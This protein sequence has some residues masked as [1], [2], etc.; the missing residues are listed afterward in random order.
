MSVFLIADGEFVAQGFVVRKFLRRFLLLILS[1]ALLIGAGWIF[2]NFRGAHEWTKAKE[3]AAKMG[4]N[5]N[6]ADYPAPEIAEKDRLMNNPIFAAEWN[7][8]VDPPLRRI[9]YMELPGV[10]SRGIRGTSYSKGKAFS[11]RQYFEEELTEEQAVEKLAELLTPVSARLDQLS[12]IILSYPVQEILPRTYLDSDTDVS[13]SA[14][15]SLKLMADCLRGEAQLAIRRGDTATALRNVRVL[16]RLR[17]NSRGPLVINLLVGDAILLSGSLV[18]WEGVRQHAWTENDLTELARLFPTELNTASGIEFLSYEAT[19]VETLVDGTLKD[20]VGYFGLFEDTENERTM[21]EEI[22]FW[23]NFKG[24]TGWQS[25]RK[26][27]VLHQYLD[28]L[29]AKDVWDEP[30]RNEFRNVFVVD[31]DEGPSFHPLAYFR[32]QGLGGMV[33]VIAKNT[34]KLRLIRIVISLEQYHLKHGS[35]P[36]TLSELELNFPIIDSTDPM[37]RPME[38]ER[39]P[40]GYFILNSREDDGSSRNRSEHWQFTENP[41]SEF[42]DAKKKKKN[43]SGSSDRS[44]G[45]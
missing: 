17:E 11:Y 35:Y 33:R 23:M 18:I 44:E 20:G 39:T 1:L 27:T 42:K 40:D 38:Y 8:E 25:W 15:L 16:H 9:H 6:I 43:T 28:L 13:T 34:M 41:R 4:V 19:F 2:E 21:T 5:L 10:K 26:A 7:Q 45:S 14:V 29:E 22:R 24:P 3:R 36:E 30:W 12:E 32:S 31:F 37:Q